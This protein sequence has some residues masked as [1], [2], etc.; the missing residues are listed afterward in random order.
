MWFLLLPIIKQFKVNYFTHENLHCSKQIRPEEAVLPTIPTCSLFRQTPSTSPEI[1]ALIL[2]PAGC[3]DVKKKNEGGSL[4][5]QNRQGWQGP[6]RIT[7]SNPCSKQGAQDHVQL[8]VSTFR[9]GDAPAPWASC[10]SW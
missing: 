9:G 10:S 5:L 7:C 2:T 3:F 8:S 6:L 1:R 4:G